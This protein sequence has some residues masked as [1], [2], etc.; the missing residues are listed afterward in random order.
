MFEQ[1]KQ[2]I[3]EF[4]QNPLPTFCGL[5]IA[6]IVYLVLMLIEQQSQKDALQVAFRE[7]LVAS[8]QAC[9]LKQAEW[10]NKFFESSLRQS[11]IEADQLKLEA[12]LRKFK[13]R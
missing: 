6:A 2:L 12:E 5:T 4:R 10:A 8:E 1:I 11:K 13:K 9:A 7:Q 3:Q